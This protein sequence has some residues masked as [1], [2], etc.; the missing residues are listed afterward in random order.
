MDHRYFQRSGAACRPNSI[1]PNPRPRTMEVINEV[2]CVLCFR[3]CAI[4]HVEDRTHM[5]ISIRVK[6]TA[7][8]PREAIPRGISYPGTKGGSDDK[9]AFSSVGGALAILRL[10]GSMIR[11]TNLSPTYFLFQY[12]FITAAVAEN[13]LSTIPNMNTPTHVPRIARS[14]FGIQGPNST[15]SPEV[16]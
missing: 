3:R 1:S 8:V 13:H 4:T 10:T 5:T 9:I 12:A 6:C 16:K 7:A 14:V 11:Q 2:F 15:L